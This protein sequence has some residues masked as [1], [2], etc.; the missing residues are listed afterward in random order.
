MARAS[1]EKS[2]NTTNV[3][4]NSDIEALAAMCLW[5][6]TERGVSF[7]AFN[8]LCY[9]LVARSC[10]GTGQWKRNIRTLKRRENNKEYD[11]L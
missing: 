10:E 11:V 4:D 6:G 5:T 7:F 1:G 8:K 9:H 2:I 3:A